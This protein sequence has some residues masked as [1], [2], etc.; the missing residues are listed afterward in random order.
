MHLP[1]SLFKF[2][3]TLLMALVLGCSSNDHRLVSYPE[4]QGAA[5]SVG[6]WH[7]SE[8]IGTASDRAYLAVWRG[9]P[10]SLGGGKHVFSVPVSEC[11]PDIQVALAAGENPWA[12]GDRSVP[13]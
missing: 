10:A 12:R 3:P 1:H 4:F 9:G 7:Y 8:Y 11:P 5:T 2:A 6:S 13:E